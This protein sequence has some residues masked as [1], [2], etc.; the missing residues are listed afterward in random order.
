[1][2]EVLYERGP[3]RPPSEAN[4]LLLRLV[5]NCPWNRCR[6]CPV[7]KH[8]RFTIRKK[9]HLLKEIQ[10]IQSFINEWKQNFLNSGRTNCHRTQQ[11]VF[12]DFAGH[13]A[14]GG[15]IAVV[16]VFFQ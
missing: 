10:E 12:K 1:M 7:Y 5:R 14:A 15:K 6:F 3:I 4:S 2:P 16:L 13:N 9:H 8:R 11:D